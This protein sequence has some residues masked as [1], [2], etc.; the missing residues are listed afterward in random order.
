MFDAGK[1]MEKDYAI[2]ARWFKAA[3]VDKGLTSKID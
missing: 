2:A 3:A 1:G